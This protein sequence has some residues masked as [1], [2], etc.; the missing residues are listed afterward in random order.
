MTDVKSKHPTFDSLMN[1]AYD[2][3]TDQMSKEQFMAQLVGLEVFAVHYGN[4]N[5]Q[6]EN[7]GFAQWQGNYYQ[8]DASVG[9]IQTFLR[10]IGTDEAREVLGLLG[11]FLELGREEDLESEYDYD[12][13]YERQSDLCSQFYKINGVVLDQ[14]EALLASMTAVA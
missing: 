13:W 1:A 3:W 14:A 7:G 9:A 8:T 4:L 5:Y 2:R 10:M 6:V 11:Q 12:A